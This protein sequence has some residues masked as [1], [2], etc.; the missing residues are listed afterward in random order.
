MKLS[1]ITLSFLLLACTSRQAKDYIE[2]DRHLKTDATLAR[3][4]N[5]VHTIYDVVEV[6]D[7][8][9]P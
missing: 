3:K 5:N 7:Q 2:L 1:P 4:K 8:G 9:H 6:A